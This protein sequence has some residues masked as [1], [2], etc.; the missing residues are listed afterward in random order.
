MLEE[1]QN[2]DLGNTQSAP[3]Q[4]FPPASPQSQ[5]DFGQQLEPQFQMP[6]E[7]EEPFYKKRVFI[8]GAAAVVFLL[9]ILTAWAFYAVT[10]MPEIEKHKSNPTPN[11]KPDIT[12][13]AKDILWIDPQEVPNLQVFDKAVSERIGAVNSYYKVATTKYSEEIYLVQSKIGATYKY[14]R[15]KKDSLGKIYFLKAASD[16]LPPDAGFMKAEPIVDDKN[17]YEELTI[18]QEIRLSHGGYF[19]KN[20]QSEIFQKISNTSKVEDTKNGS[21]Y[22]AL[23]GNVSGSV[24]N[25]N[26]YLKLADSSTV[27]YNM[28]LD[29]FDKAS[30]VPNLTIDGA[31]VTAKYST[32]AFN[33][34][35]GFD[36]TV[37]S[38][39]N[40]QK[41]KLISIGQF[42]GGEEIYTISD[43]KSRLATDLFLSYKDARDKKLLDMKNK[44]IRD[45]SVDKFYVLNPR[46]V[47]FIKDPVG[48]YMIFYRTDLKAGG[49]C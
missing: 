5:P 19:K 31:K 2:N 48:Q 40:S 26:F 13:P 7:D 25:R 35:A 33:G 14:Y 28:V 17:T 6:V 37:V 49:S 30:G 42:E 46:A 36:S 27:E 44:A 3:P 16:P 18:P 21:F 32:Y 12:Q 11:N 1:G 22:V 38:D 24:V 39:F 34:C 8:V 10:R 20:N 47:F 23:H 43:V 41:S 9:I 15:F 29:Y 4:G 45:L